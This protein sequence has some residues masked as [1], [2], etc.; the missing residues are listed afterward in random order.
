[1]PP[2]GWILAGKKDSLQEATDWKR[3]FFAEHCYT[4]VEDPVTAAGYGPANHAHAYVDAFL[5][6]GWHSKK[7]RSVGD[8]V[9]A[10]RC[11]GGRL[12]S[13]PSAACSSGSSD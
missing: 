3:S 1:M 7:R 11:L 4:K 10:C 12:S 8:L 2:K 5:Q 9:T 6:L 13:G